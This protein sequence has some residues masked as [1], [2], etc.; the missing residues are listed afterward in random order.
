MMTFKVI[1]LWLPLLLSTVSQ[2]WALNITCPEG[3]ITI[4]G[5]DTVL[6]QVAAWKAAY[7]GYCPTADISLIGGGYSIAA[8]PDTFFQPQ[9]TSVDGWNFDCKRSSRKAIMVS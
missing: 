9:A 1:L 7:Q 4:A 8:M 3:S 6:R 5:A 2:S